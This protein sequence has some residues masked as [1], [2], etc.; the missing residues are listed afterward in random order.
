MRYAREGIPRESAGS[1]S[2]KRVAGLPAFGGCRPVASALVCRPEDMR[3]LYRHRDHSLVAYYK[4][5]LEAE[6]I[7]VM[8]RNEHL[9][10]T[11][12]SEIP[13][14]E[15]Y[16]NICVLNDEDYERAWHIMR[17][18]MHENA[19]HSDEEVVCPSCGEVNPGNFDVCFSC[20]GD[21]HQGELGSKDP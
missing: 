15:F 12:L 13:I 2:C 6:G 17:K 4:Q 14:P 7:A 21:L 20:Q 11:G 3:E 19:E 10:M 18:A 1:W 8:L 9:T 5:L 16:P